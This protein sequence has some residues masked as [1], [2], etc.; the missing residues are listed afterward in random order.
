M[1]FVKCYQETTTHNFFE[2]INQEPSRDIS[3]KEQDKPQKRLK[4]SNSFGAKMRIRGQI[5]NSG[6]ENYFHIQNL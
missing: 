5:R 1:Y 2:M 3:C 6:G 4:N